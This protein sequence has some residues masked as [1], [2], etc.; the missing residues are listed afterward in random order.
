MQWR[1]SDLELFNI[2]FYLPKYKD[3]KLGTTALDS[4]VLR[5]KA[6]VS[7]KPSAH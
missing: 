1:M 2:L 3:Y 5:F 4:I 6:S 7:G